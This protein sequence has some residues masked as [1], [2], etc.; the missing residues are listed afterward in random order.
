MCSG[1]CLGTYKERFAIFVT[2]GALDSFNR[3]ELQG[4]IGHEFS[5]IFHDDVELNMKLISII[6]AM[7][8]ISM[9]GHSMLKG[10]FKNTSRSSKNKSEGKVAILVLLL[11]IILIGFIGSIFSQIIQS[12]ISR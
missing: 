1:E 10:A 6:F 7:N 9:I 4:V 2:Q 12:A 3:D 8:C 5:H 11:M